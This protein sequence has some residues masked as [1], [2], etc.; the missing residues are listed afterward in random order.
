MLTAKWNASGIK[1]AQD[2]LKRHE[3]EKAEEE[4]EQKQKA[5]RAKE[6]RD[7]GVQ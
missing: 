2:E 7:A 5:L 4:L 3:K 1:D 6:K